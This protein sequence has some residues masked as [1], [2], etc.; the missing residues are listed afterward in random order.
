M[1]LELSF[2]LFGSGN[3]DYCGA[4]SATNMSAAPVPSSLVFPNHASL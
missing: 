2:F 4:N 3:E 1:I